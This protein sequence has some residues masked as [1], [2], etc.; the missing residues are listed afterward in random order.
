MTREEAIKMLQ[1]MKA[2]NL[3]LDDLYTRDKYEALVTA[4]KALKQEPCEDW[5]DVPSDEMTLEQARQAVKDLRKK[6]AGCLE[7]KPILEEML[8]HSDT[9]KHEY[10][11]KDNFL[12]DLHVQVPISIAVEWNTITEQEIVKPYLDKIRAEIKV[13]IVHYGN[14]KWRII[15]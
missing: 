3:N 11:H 5:C 14:Q 15:P 4:I 9:A 10:I 12:V 1:G 13:M 8:F 6:L 7:Q 2:D